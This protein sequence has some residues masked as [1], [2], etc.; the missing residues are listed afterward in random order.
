MLVIGADDPEDR[1]AWEALVRLPGGAEAWRAA[2]ARRRRMDLVT[3][4][5]RGRTWLA[6][7]MHRLSV[8]SRRLRTTPAVELCLAFP[9]AQLDALADAELSPVDDSVADQEVVPR[10]GQTVPVHVQLGHQ[11]GLNVTDQATVDVRYLTHGRDGPLPSRTWRLEP[12]EAPVLLVALIGADAGSP[13]SE[14][15]AQATA[16]AGVLVLEAAPVGE[17]PA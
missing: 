3:R 6:S 9:E 16:A 7:A 1:A 4:A 2:V 17:P 13:L 12:G 11:I 14:A 10:W 8:L 15:L 5:V